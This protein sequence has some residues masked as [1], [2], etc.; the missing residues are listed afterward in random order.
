MATI[1][2]NDFFGRSFGTINLQANIDTRSA[3]CKTAILNS[4][5][6]F[7]MKTGKELSEEFQK[8]MIP[9]AHQVDQNKLQFDRLQIPDQELLQ[10]NRIELGKF[11]AR[12]ALLDEEY[13]ASAWLR[14][15]SNFE[16][17]RGERYAASHRKK[18]AEQ[19]Y[20]NLKRRCKAVLGE[21]WTCI[22]AVKKEEHNVKHTVLKSI[23]GTLDM[24]TGFL[25]QGQNFPGEHVKTFLF[26]NID[27]KTSNPYS[28][29]SNLCVAKQARRQGIASNMLRVAL[30]SAKAKGVD[31]VFVHVHKHN[32]PAQELYEKIGFEVAEEASIE[33][34]G[35]QTYLLRM[36][37]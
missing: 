7:I 37:T 33:L 32:K 21:K 6:N 11:V 5:S 26:S 10:E 36:K 16:D 3:R 8:V 29:I 9:G 20:I 28:Y 31:R 2:R 4:S 25:S 35:E 24:N 23:V 12:E 30:L 15:E 1:I 18:Y 13:W 34:S 27:G 17:K 22:V 19:E 14:A